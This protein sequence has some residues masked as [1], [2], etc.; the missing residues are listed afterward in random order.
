[1][2]WV[3]IKLPDNFPGEG[4]LGKVWK[5]ITEGGISGL[6]SPWQIRR[7][8]KARAEVRA[9]EILLL[10]QAKR[11]AADITAGRKTRDEKGNLIDSMPVDA[12]DLLPPSS[13]SLH[14]LLEGLRQEQDRRLLERAINITSIIVMAEEEAHKVTD[15]D[16]SDEPVHQDWFARWRANAEEVSDEQIRSLWARILVGEV[17]KPGRFSLHTLDFMRRLSKGDAE[18]IARLAPFV[19]AD[20]DLF[21]RHQHLNPV[22]AKNQLGMHELMELQNLGVL[23]GVGSNLQKDLAIDGPLTIR[24]RNR[25]IHLQPPPA[26]LILPLAGVTKV[27]EEVMSLGKFQANEEYVAVV[28]HIFLTEGFQ[29]SLGNVREAANGEWEVVDLEPQSL[30]RPFPFR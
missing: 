19:T 14:P 3:E 20:R 13:T 12:P 17:Q 6:L 7:V 26:R 1:M 28:A 11:D 18:L 29:V 21:V 30:G 16:V 8:G 23:S 2:A 25:V 15:E 10:A 5:T 9:H 27:G 4:L 24:F 22:L